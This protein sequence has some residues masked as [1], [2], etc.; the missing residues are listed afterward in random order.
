MKKF[1]IA[2]IL[3]LAVF[4]ASAEW[5]D[6]G[7]Y[8]WKDAGKAVDGVLYD[9][10]RQTSPRLMDLWVMRIDLNK[11][12][13]FM[14]SGKA[15]KYGETIPTHPKLKIHTLRQRTVDF[16]YDARAKDI[17][18][19]AAVNAAPWSP[20][21]GTYSPY[22]SKLGLLISDGE[23][24][25]PVLPGRA[26]FVVY[27]NGK[28]ALKSFGKDDSLKNIR[29]AITGFGFVLK[30]GKVLPGGKS[31]APRTG[32]GLSKDKNYLYWV[33]IDGRQPTFSMGATVNEVGKILKY[34]GA[35]DGANMDGGGSSSFVVWDPAKDQAKMLNHQPRGGIR[36]VG[37]SIGIYLNR[38]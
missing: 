25:S 19:V 35:F 22:A 24:I 36:A 33:V 30:E 37:A 6:N 7:V 16:M 1:Y 5:W 11:N 31:L 4:T 28:V 9:H 23:L 21:D 18:M 15:E 14:V 13:G 29:H 34:L 20:W 8:S 26:T 3:L 12:F 2:L 32:F 27:R 17:K 10:I 38:E